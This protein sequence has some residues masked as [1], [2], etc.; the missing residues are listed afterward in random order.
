ML[1]LCPSPTCGCDMLLLLLLL[2]VHK[3]H[4]CTHS[5]FFFYL[6]LGEL[7]QS[8]IILVSGCVCVAVS[9]LLCHSTPCPPCVARAEVEIHENLFENM[10]TQRPA[11]AHTHT[12]KQNKETFFTRAYPKIVS[13]YS[14]KPMKVAKCYAGVDCRCSPGFRISYIRRHH[15]R[16]ECVC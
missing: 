10:H 13:Q 12:R 9:S 8:R 16:R 5:P 14:L 15:R 4:A 6:S 2:F 11:R 7:K 1:I 3:R